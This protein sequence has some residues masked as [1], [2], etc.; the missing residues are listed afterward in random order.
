MA[1]T[2][3]AAAAA[4][5]RRQRTANAE[6]VKAQVAKPGGRKRTKYEEAGVP[7]EYLSDRGTFRVGY[8][9]KYKS[10]LIGAALAAETELGRVPTKD[11]ESE[12]R[13]GWAHGALRALGWTH[14]LDKSRSSRAAKAQGKP[15]GKRLTDEARGEITNALATLMLVDEAR[16]DADIA[17][18][19]RA[20]VGM[21]AT[22]QD[23]ADILGELGLAGPEPEAAQA[24]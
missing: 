18:A 20:L 21:L 8:D 6:E 16:T 2:K 17:D 24:S 23:R 14:L 10:H 3:Q 15:K 13:I 12:G 4:S 9:A 11:E 1:T 5:L 22:G 19:T 7:A